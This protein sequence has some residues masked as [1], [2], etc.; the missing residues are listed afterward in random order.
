[1]SQEKEFRELAVKRGE[2]EATSKMYPNNYI[3]TS[4]YSPLT[5]IPRNLF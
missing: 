4:K 1:M 3:S 2:A 5:I